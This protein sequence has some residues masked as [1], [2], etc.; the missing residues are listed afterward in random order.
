MLKQQVMSLAVIQQ[1]K[2]ITI[3]Q[4]Q[5]KT[6]LYLAL[7]ICY[8]SSQECIPSYQPQ[9]LHEIITSYLLWLAITRKREHQILNI[10]DISSIKTDR[11]LQ[12]SYFTYSELLIMHTDMFHIL[13]RNLVCDGS[14]KH[15][16]RHPWGFWSFWRAINHT[17]SFALRH[18]TIRKCLK[19]NNSL[20]RQ[21]RKILKNLKL[22]YPKKKN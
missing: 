22:K 20:Y 3:F 8:C 12:W 13:G 17:S 10:R 11:V 16:K 5:T 9:L 1:Q 4:S 7:K 15:R 14:K 6:F 2:T 21:L 18:F 19:S